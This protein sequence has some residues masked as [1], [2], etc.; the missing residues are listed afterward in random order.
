MLK[1]IKNFFDDNSKI[2]G[3]CAFDRK[4]KSYGRQRDYFHNVFNRNS[5]VP[6]ADNNIL[7]I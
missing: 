2:I 4:A 6:R 3:L 1:F 5:F 7:L